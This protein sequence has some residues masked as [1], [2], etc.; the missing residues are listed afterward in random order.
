ML[1]AISKLVLKFSMLLSFAVPAWSQE[2]GIG[3]GTTPDIHR[4]EASAC[5]SALNSARSEAMR[6]AAAAMASPP[7][8]TEEKCQC[9]SNKDQTRWSCTA[10]VN[11]RK[12][13]K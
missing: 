1:R 12:S 9:Q 2:S 13:N 7:T 5:D 11:W 8:I 3:R 4:T 6:Q 10:F